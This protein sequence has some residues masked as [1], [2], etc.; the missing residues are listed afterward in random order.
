MRTLYSLGIF[1]VIA[2]TASQQAAI[3]QNIDPRIPV[4]TPRQQQDWTREE[5]FRTPEPRSVFS[6]NDRPVDELDRPRVSGRNSHRGFEVRNSRGTYIA[7]TSVEDAKLAERIVGETWGTLNQFADHFAQEHKLPDFGLSAVQVAVDGELPRG[8]RDEPVPVWIPGRFENRIVINVSEGRPSLEE[9]IPLLRAATAYVYMHVAEFDR[10]LP[11]WVSDGFAQAVVLKH[12][13]NEGLNA[14]ADVPL[15]LLRGQG[16]KL[17]RETPV[18]MQERMLAEEQAKEEP[19]GNLVPF[20]LFADDAGH[21]Q[22]FFNTL[23]TTLAERQEQAPFT[24]EEVVR[25]RQVAF[26]YPAA[27]VDDRAPAYETNF[28]RWS[29][30][31]DAGVPQFVTKENEDPEL[32]QLERELFVIL[33]LAHKV[34]A[35]PPAAKTANSPRTKIIEFTKNGPVERAAQ[36]N[37]AVPPQVQ[38][39]LDVPQLIAALD[40]NANGWTTVDVDGTLILSEDREAVEALVERF[41]EDVTSKQEKDRWVWNYQLAGGRTLSGWLEP[42]SKEDPTLV[43]HFEVRPTRPPVAGAQTKPMGR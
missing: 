33:K 1:G 26:E 29:E 21:A 23:K 8:G 43:T 13:G 37:A 15:D 18:E 5:D 42:K 7:T 40:N 31:P 28:A 14:I 22:E 20:L 30:H 3:A 27:A 17:F 2:W 12:D 6:R 25:R 39:I 11:Q 36:A 24:R 19:T 32:V 38:K 16:I 10:Q 4:V 41:R 9:Q 35:P 34:T